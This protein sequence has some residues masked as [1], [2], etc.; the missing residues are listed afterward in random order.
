MSYR[1]GE[2][3]VQGQSQPTNVIELA[4]GRKTTDGGKAR[5]RRR[6]AV[7][8]DAGHTASSVDDL[9][10]ASFREPIGD[11][12]ML[13]ADVSYTSPCDLDPCVEYVAS[14]WDPA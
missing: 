9:I 2:L 4:F 12:V 1:I 10:A 13:R 14:A 8:F 3:N 11:L 6:R 5:I 7:L